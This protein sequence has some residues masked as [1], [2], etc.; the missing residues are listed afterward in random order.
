ME[1]IKI[2]DFIELPRMTMATL[3]RIL[4]YRDPFKGVTVTIDEYNNLDEFTKSYYKPLETFPDGTIVHERYS[5]RL[6]TFF[7][8]D[9]ICMSSMNIPDEDLKDRHIISIFNC[10]NC[11]APLNL[12]KIR[13]NG[14]CHCEYCGTN[15]YVWD[16][17]E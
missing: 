5:D 4:Y 16:K 9:Y 7:D 17:G 6:Y 15:P 3:G 8:N 1:A 2:Q 12:E 10:P 11:G 14:T 13:D